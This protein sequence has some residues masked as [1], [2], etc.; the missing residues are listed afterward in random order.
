ML[1]FIKEEISLLIALITLL[2]FK[3]GGAEYLAD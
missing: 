1:A 3:T 2:F